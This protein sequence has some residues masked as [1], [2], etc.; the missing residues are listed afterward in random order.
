[1]SLLP[2]WPTVVA[3][4]LFGFVAGTWADHAVM[5]HKVDKLVAEH[6]QAMAIANAANQKKSDD[7]QDTVDTLHTDA[8]LKDEQHA[9]DLEAARSSVRSGDERLSI[10]SACRANANTPASTTTGTRAEERADIVPEVA[11]ALVSVAGASAKD[12][13]DYNNLLDQYNAVCK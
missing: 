9:K 5:A 3:G 13:R 7:L 2:S 11:D 10:R 4:L 1:M 6:A 12:V 8:V